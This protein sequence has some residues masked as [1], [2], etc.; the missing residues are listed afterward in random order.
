MKQYLL[1]VLLLIALPLL[2]ACSEDFEDFP[3]VEHS[4]PGAMVGQEE[5][6]VEFPVAD[7]A[8]NLPFG[9][10][11]D[12]VRAFAALLNKVDI[13]RAKHMGETQITDAQFQEIKTFVDEN[14]KRATGEETYKAIFEWITGNLKYAWQGTPAYLDP[15]DVF[16]HKTCVCQGYANLLKTMMLT[17]GYAAF[18]VNGQ[19]GTIGAHAWNYVHD[20]QKWWVSDPTNGNHFLM[21]NI[22]EY[23]IR[24]MP[25][26][27]DFLLFEDD[28][29]GYGFEN[30]RLNINIIKD[31]APSAV[32]LPRSIAGYKVSCFDPKEELPAHVRV[33]GIPQNITT[34]SI[35][36]STLRQYTPYLE[37]VYVE[38][39]HRYLESYKGV[40]YERRKTTPV[41]IPTGIKTLELKMKETMQ[42]NDI[43]DLPVV[44][45]IYIPEGTVTIED[46]AIENCPS[47]KRVYIPESVKNI[48]ENFLYRCP[49]DVEILRTST[50]I[51]N[52]P[53]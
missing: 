46:Y 3:V 29:F 36:M 20:G 50:G 17:Q 9:K 51:D 48:G 5:I 44:E 4:A 23:A 10:E 7:D 11:G 41:Y 13:E 39:K 31:G 18:C 6:P 37:E 47:L 14:L 27:A 25:Y 34:L 52:V 26:R 32:S 45:E 40:I 49:A 35:Y 12:E 16:I 30:S 33:L 15:Y 19:L 24:L 42:K 38:E 2:N 22:S 53:M 43:Y 21:D 8:E 1:P 28:Y